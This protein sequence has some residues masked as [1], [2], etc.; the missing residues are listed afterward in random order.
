MAFLALKDPLR[1]EAS[2]TIA[3]C[4]QAGIRPIIIT[5]DHKL[6]ASAIAKEIGFKLKPGSVIT[7]EILDKTSDE[8]LKDLVAKVDVFARV[9][10]HHKLRIVKALQSRG[11]VVAMTGDGINDSPA[12]KAADIGVCLGSG[13]DIAKETAD[14]VLLDDN[15]RL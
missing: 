3:I 15:L 7:G 5:G 10:P 14:I 8:K 11:E 2:Q 4:R 9:S 6:T 13:T 1:V 12:L